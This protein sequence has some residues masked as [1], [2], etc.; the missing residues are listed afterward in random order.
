MSHKILIKTEGKRRTKDPSID[1]WFILKWALKNA[2]EVCG[3][4]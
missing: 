1:E 4:D 2:I 3:L